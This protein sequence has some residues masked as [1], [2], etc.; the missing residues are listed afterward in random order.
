MTTPEPP[1]QTSIAFEPQQAWPAPGQSTTATPAPPAVRRRKL[2]PLLTAGVAGALAGALIVGAI[3]LGTALDG[4]P[5]QADAGH[6]ADTSCDLFAQLPGT[7][8]PE[9]M[10]STSTTARLQ[11]AVAL[12]VAAAEQDPQYRAL[13]AAAQQAIGAAR[14]G[15]LDGISAQV[16]AARAQCDKL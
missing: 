9:T 14:N 4:G 16:R 12:A 7:W 15:E 5:A 13:A 2:G 10:T 11:A 6:D 1:E 3:W 8:Q